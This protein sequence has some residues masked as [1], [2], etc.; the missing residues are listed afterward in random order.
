ML[1]C[2]SGG[3]ARTVV[4]NLASGEKIGTLPEPVPASLDG[5]RPLC[6]IAQCDARYP[7][8]IRLFLKAARIGHYERGVGH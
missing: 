5:F 1:D 8:K 2:A 3:M 6:F 7:V 4:V